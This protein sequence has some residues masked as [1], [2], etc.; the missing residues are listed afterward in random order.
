MT[1][2]KLRKCRSSSDLQIH[3]MVWTLNQVKDTFL[4]QNYFDSSSV[5]V[6]GKKVAKLKAGE[7][8]KVMFYNNRALSKTFPRQLGRIVCDS[9]ITPIRVKKWTDIS[10]AA[11]K[12]IFDA[13]K[14]HAS[15]QNKFCILSFFPLS[16]L[17]SY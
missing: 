15:L 13:I 8:I 12:H 16:I 17:Y 10:P 9:N 14:V 1:T 3:Q 5:Y 6:L 4:Y 11:Q 2:W 7:K